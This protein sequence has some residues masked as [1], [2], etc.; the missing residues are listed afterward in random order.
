MTLSDLSRYLRRYPSGAFSAQV[1]VPFALQAAFGR[2][3]IEVGLTTRDEALAVVRCRLA[4]A[5]YAT[6]FAAIAAAPADL[7]P[8]MIREQR[9]EAFKG[10]ATLQ[11]AYV[12][13]AAS[14]GA[15]D[16]DAAADAPSMTPDPADPV[17]RL[18]AFDRE[19]LRQSAAR[20]LANMRAVV[21]QLD[22][23]PAL[24]VS[25][26][27]AA[28]L[29]AT[30]TTRDAKVAPRHTARVA[31]FVAQH[32]D[33]AIDAEGFRD[34]VDAYCQGLIAAGSH[35]VS[36]V[37]PIAGTFRAITGWA[38]E[39]GKIARDPLLGVKRAFAD[40]RAASQKRDAYTPAQI[41][42]I[43]AAMPAAYAGNPDRLALVSLIIATGCRAAE[44][45]QARVSDVREHAGNYILTIGG[46]FKREAQPD[47][48]CPRSIK[49]PESRR[50]I[51][52]HPCMSGMIRDTLA[53]RAGD[54]AK[55]GA[56]RVRLFG[57]EGTPADT[58]NS[59]PL[60]RT[61]GASV[62]RVTDKA[63]AAAGVAKTAKQSPLHSFRH[64]ITD[65]FGERAKMCA[66]YTGH[67]TGPYGGPSTL[68]DML[69]VVPS[70]P[71]FGDAAWKADPLALAA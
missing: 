44:A 47:N 52:L 13:G 55:L 30:A 70:L 49:R 40:T 45:A 68:S 64:S 36:G 60:I 10:L 65:V 3:Q 39:T 5:R 63:C 54:V 48:G 46:A 67:T 4:L 35:S 71:V 14:L 37:A 61:L 29:A 43:V 58:S 42:A 16:P 20:D 11:A 18:A 26:M 34:A 19:A 6:W 1:P 23:P 21:A 2:K 17:A 9:P 50:V 24:S 27:C 7:R 66:T 41:A 38:L 69:A 12:T 28:W 32:G 57:A 25:A 53:R 56:L 31:A 33:M 22:A 8:V 59:D 51:P 62:K 15:V